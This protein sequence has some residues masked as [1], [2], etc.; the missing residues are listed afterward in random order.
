MPKPLVRSSVWLVLILGFCCSLTVLAEGEIT[1]SDLSPADDGAPFITSN[2]VV[3]AVVGQLYNYDVN[4]IGSPPPVFSLG[5]FPDGMW[6]EQYSGLIQWFPTWR[7]FRI[8]KYL[9]N[10]DEAMLLAGHSLVVSV[11]LIDQLPNASMSPFA[12]LLIGILS[13]RTFINRDIQTVPGPER[14]SKE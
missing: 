5:H 9:K 4:A 3:N 12:W 6:I 2:P 7:M 13:G 10:R 14:N 8:L 11:I 1:G